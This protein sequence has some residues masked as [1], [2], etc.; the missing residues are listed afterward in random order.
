[1]LE[2]GDFDNDGDLD[3]VA[4]GEQQA[5]GNASTLLFRNNG[6]SF[7][8]VS[9]VPFSNLKEGGAKFIDFDNDNDLDVVVMGQNASNTP[10]LILYQNMGNSSFVPVLNSGLTGLYRGGLD[11]ADYNN[12]GYADLVTTGLD[13]SGNLRTILYTNIGGTFQES[14]IDLIGLYD[15]DIAWHDGSDR[16]PDLIISG[17][18]FLG[19]SYTLY[20]QNFEG[21]LTRLGG[22][23]LLFPMAESSIATNN[24]DKDGFYEYVVMG[25]EALN[26][27]AFVYRAGDQTEALPGFQHGDIVWVDYDS[28]GD[29]DLV[30]TGINLQSNQVQ[31]RLYRNTNDNYTLVCGA[32]PEEG[33]NQSRLAVADYDQDG[34]LDLMFTSFDSMGVAFGRLYRNDSSSV[35]SPPS[36]PTALS[37]SANCNVL[38]ISWNQANDN[39]SPSHNLTYAIKVGTSIGGNDIYP[40]LA[41]PNGNRLLTGEGNNG[42]HTSIR[43]PVSVSGQYYVGLQTIDNGYAASGFMIDSIDVVIVLDSQLVISELSAQWPYANGK[44]TQTVLFDL[45][46]NGF[47]DIFM[48]T[49]RGSLNPSIDSTWVMYNDGSDFSIQTLLEHEEIGYFRD[50]DDY[51]GDGLP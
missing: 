12:D 10:L 34:D 47:P 3:V 7:S 19:D 24:R 16:F 17:K 25:A 11:V 44:S 15:G 6:S 39:E 51:N 21:D 49:R 13:I 4:N 50:F 41:L 36:L 8:Q 48:K 37:V 40:G 43:I 22:N 28:D 5:G 35:N 42:S 27:Q 23:N 20:Y 2:W 31:T 33:N 32:L 18:G 30:M 46:E 29:N 1:S 45:D 9:P 38:E 26:S 14:S